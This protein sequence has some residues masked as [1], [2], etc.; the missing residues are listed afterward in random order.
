[1]SA[2]IARK[3]ALAYWGFSKKATSRATSGVE[4]DIIK[5]NGSGG[6]DSATAP[7]KK[8]AKKVEKAW[9]DYIGQIGGYGRISFEKLV[10]FA[11][12]ARSENES[13][14][15]SDLEEVKK[16]SQILINEYPHYFIARAKYKKEI[17]EI[18]INTKN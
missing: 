8:F 4:I 12:Q 7:M 10:D 18:L 5:G 17:M 3:V 13:I 14:G 11:A 2:K 16:W 1:M 6:L 9:E 15:K